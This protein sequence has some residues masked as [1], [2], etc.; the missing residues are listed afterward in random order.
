MPKNDFMRNN[1]LNRVKPTMLRDVKTE[2]LLVFCRTALERYF[3]K[4]DEANYVASVGTNA[5]TTYVYDTLRSLL[6][7]LEDSVVNV[8]YFIDLVQLSNSSPLFRKLAKSEEALINYYDVM[9]KV[10]QSHYRDQLAYLPEFL[11]ICIL[12]N[13]MGEEHSVA[14]YP[15]LKD[16]DF[17]E[18]MSK[19]EENREYFQSGD[20]CRVKDI[21]HLSDK[22]TYALDAYKYKVNKKRVSKVRNRSK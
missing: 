21:H 8:D 15:F 4:I 18:L 9:A 20:V 7:K 11:V 17:L 16:I 6:V 19:F 22:I 2:A 13:W 3:A 5:D 1:C 10:I 12:E 14:L